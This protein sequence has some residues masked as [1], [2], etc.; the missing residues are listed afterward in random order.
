MHYPSLRY[1]KFIR[2]SLSACL[3]GLLIGSVGATGASAQLTPRELLEAVNGRAATAAAEMLPAAL[4]SNAVAP[5]PD[6][7]Q[8]SAEQPLKLLLSLSNRQVYVY[9]GEVLETSYPVAIGRPGWETPTGEFEVFSRVV[10]PGWTNPLTGESMAPGAD[11]PLGDRWMAF[12]TDGTNSI[13]F[14]GTPDRD[15]VGQAAS[16]GCV[17]MYN[18]DARELFE[19][20][21]IGTP[22]IVEP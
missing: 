10:E 8:Q 5:E 14:H 3:G 7:V 15:S 21:A 18:E 13:G 9:R 12:W 16:H 17:R 2:R 19:M 1:R 22:V 4:E 6:A 11:N 20:V